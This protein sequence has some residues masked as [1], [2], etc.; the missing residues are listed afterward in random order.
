[1][2]KASFKTWNIIT[3]W[4]VFTIALLTYYL[5]MEPTV[6]FWDC[7][8]YISTSSKLEIGHAPGAP[9]F[10]I[11]GAF[12]ASFA[13]DPMQISVMVNMIS[14]FASAFAVLFTFWSITHLTLKIALKNNVNTTKK[15]NC[16][17]IASGVVGALAFTFSDSFW[18]SAVEGEVYAMASLIMALQFWLGL[19]WV[20]DFEK[21]RGHKWLIL[22]SLI[23]GLTFG[24]QFMGFLVIPSL[25]LLYFFKRYKKV[26]FKNFAI[27]NVLS[28]LLLLFVYK[29]SLTYV[30]KL[31]GWGELFFV[32]TFH[33]PFNSGT[34]IIALAFILS[35]YLL[36]K[37]SR[38]KQLYGLQTLSLCLLFMFIGFSSWLML[39]IRANAG[40]TINEGNPSDARQLLAYYN[41]EQYGNE[42]SLLYGSYYSDMFA[43][44]DSVQ[45]YK[46]DNPKYEQDQQLGKYVIVNNYKNAISNKNHEQEGF[47]P[48]MWS[49]SDDNAANY[50]KLTKPL[51]FTIKPEYQSS[52]ELQNA[53]NNFKL[54]FEKG[55]YNE[56]DYVHFLQQFSQYINVKPP[57]IWD[58]IQFL[59]N[60]QWGYMYAR[61]L[62]WNFV[63]RQDDIQGELNHHGNWLS[64]INAIDNTRLGSQKNLPSD[65]LQNKARN[66]YYFL[67]LILGILGLV[68]QAKV[69]IKNF[70]VL[71][72]Y[73]IFTGIAIQFYTNIRPFEPRERDYSVVGSFYV[74]S[75]W[76]GIG[77]FALYEMLKK[78]FTTKLLV[79]AVTLSCILAVPFLMSFKN[80][81][82]HDRSNK[83]TAQFLGKAY[84]DS[85]QKNADAILFTFGDND[86]FSTWYQQE[87]ENYRTDVRVINA[88][89]YLQT[90]WYIDQLK[91]KSYESNPIPSQLT[92]K[93][94]VYGTRDVLYYQHMTDKRWDIKDFMKW[95]ASDS[96]KTKLQLKSGQEV[97]FYP[98]N[99]I[100][101]YVNKENVLK[102]GLVKPED[103][104]KIVDYIDID[105]PDYI[106]KNHLM[107]LD[108]LANNDWNRPIYFTGGTP[109]DADY[110]WLKDYLE[111]DGIAYKLIPIKTS[112]KDHPYS[113]GSVNAELSYNIMKKWDWG[114][115][116][117][118]TIYYDPV[119]RRNGINYR[120]K[121][122]RVANQFIAE[123]KFKK[124]E[125]TL[126][127]GMKNLPF[128][129]F[130]S[131]SVLEPFVNG[132]YK[133][134]AKTKARNLYKKIAKKY[135]ENLNYYASLN[136][137]WQM[138]YGSEIVTD[139]SR[140]RSLITVL[141]NNNDNEL[142]MAET[143]QFNE[144]LEKFKHFY[145][146]TPT[147]QQSNPNSKS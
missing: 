101:V 90:D 138:K 11:L 46:D 132:Y 17:I 135:Q 89:M 61:Y 71:C 44:Q 13:K 10:Q 49:T 110:I 47:L 76:I 96:P 82:D 8:E 86:T 29:F 43:G 98:T 20:D 116:A 7:A 137:D 83:Y 88:A 122:G 72:V 140:Y 113:P 36:I 81:D 121:L 93:Q 123:G 62:F 16:I 120:L 94:Y 68:F 104:D 109:D 24:I 69:N 77:V 102:S 3:G 119:T 45:P 66:T 23:I 28:I 80:W 14:V 126:D 32:N 136:I 103:A 141:V 64:G 55:T 133:V 38:K 67:P 108:I 56:A 143:K 57:S 48:R 95:I 131:Y 1:M 52:K 99:K 33:L 2:K 92:H 19:K 34:I 87:V 15:Q 54:G 74:F 65:A 78:Y 146:Q 35:F 6:S 31:F 70:W 105:L 97:V 134:N 85:I 4:V 42:S 5:T 50:M 40:V 59:W 107:M 125:D 58:N 84:L 53:V 25:G 129:H 112:S 75:I 22:I 115:T 130:G 63:G 41:R 51:T 139:L 12:F 111:L 27:A 37:Y 106:T 100:R 118:V 91:K 26:N 79:P 117:D 145:Q 18:F 39:P 124:A 147:D 128:G 60:Y 73:F 127:M 114:N 30:L 144:Y 142:G 9:F 21:P